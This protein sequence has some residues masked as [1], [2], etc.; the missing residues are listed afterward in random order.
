MRTKYLGNYY[1]QTCNL[2]FNE[3]KQLFAH[4]E[5]LDHKYKQLLRNINT[6]IEN[7]VNDNFNLKPLHM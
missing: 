7:F 5:T 2:Y 1:C 3:A 6:L 4:G